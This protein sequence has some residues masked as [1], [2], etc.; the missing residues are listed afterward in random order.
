MK[1]LLSYW[2]ELANVEQCLRTEAETIDEALLLA[3]HEP[4]SLLRRS[5]VKSQDVVVSE[6]DL[7]AELVR[8]VD[9]G[10]AVVVAI[11]GASGVGKS[12]MVRWLRAQLKRHPR[13]DEFV[14]VTIPKTASLRRVVELILEPLPGEAYD[15]LRQDL[16]RTAEALDPD[17]AAALLGTALAE[18]L[19]AYAHRI[20]TDVRAS[21]LGREYGPRVA[22]A[23]HL[24][25]II[26]DP[27]VQDAWFRQVLTRIVRASLSGTADPLARQFH[28]V[29]LDPPAEAAGGIESNAV[30]RSLQF[31]ANAGGANR[32]DAAEVLQEVL[33]PALRTIFRFTEALQ[34][35][36][37][38]E[39]VDDIRRQL[40]RDQKELVLL[41]EDLAA[42]SGI[43]Q[44][45][46]D[47]M[48]A[49][50]DHAGERVRAP[51]RT[52]VAVTDGFLAARQTVLTRAKGQWV[53]QSEG[54]RESTIV[55]RLVDMTGRYLN[56]ARFGV[57]RL[58]AAFAESDA[59]GTGLYEWV[60]KY[61]AFETPPSQLE[62]FGRSAAGHA[63]F[64]FNEYAIRSMAA[65]ALKTGGSWI[66]N[67]R[68]Y[69]NE[70]L[71]RT[72]RLR[73]TFE[74]GQ[75]PPGNF[76]SP[77]VPATVA[78]ELQ[79]K[80]FSPGERERLQTV[81]FHWAGNPG[82]LEGS[83]L[84]S[85]T[86]FDQF[87]LPW[88]FDGEVARGQQ[89][90]LKGVPT[91]KPASLTTRTP[92]SV[93]APEPPPATPPAPAEQSSY[94]AAVEAWRSEV[95]LPQLVA[96]RTRHLLAAALDRRI[97]LSDF[98]VQGLKVE[99][100]LFW[101]PP[102]NTVSN[103]G[104]SQLRVKLAEAGAPIP[105]FVKAGLQALDRW[106]RND[107]R[108]DYSNA[109]DDYA[110]ADV[111]LDAV[112]GQ[113]LPILLDEVEREAGILMGALHRQGLVT[114][115]QGS[116]APDDAPLRQLFAAGIIDPPI[117]ENAL[118]PTYRVALD[119]RKKASASRAGLQSRLRACIGSFQGTGSKVFALDSE[120][121]KRAWRKPMPTR[122]IL[123]LKMR[124]D[125]GGEATDV[126][127][128]LSPEAID[129]VTVRLSGAF[130]STRAKIASAF[131][132]DQA[133]VQWREQ[134]MG[135]IEQSVHLSLWPSSLNPSD[136][137]K[138]VELLSSELADSVIAKAKR[139]TP[140]SAEASSL[141]RLANFSIAPLPQ[142]I[143]LS[144]HIDVLQSYLQAQ[145]KLIRDQS[146]V[147]DDHALQLRQSLIA[148]LRWEA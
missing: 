105:P 5:D 138:A 128:R 34:Q 104:Q 100:K 85:R 63:L 12:H 49:E 82:R 14:V 29:D 132:D 142:L 136:V 2:P 54:L 88:P 97:D 94:A 81:L 98:A 36:T 20:E 79:N 19:A 119:E 47:I 13:R 42:L 43:Q 69:I 91:T 92:V 87:G 10:S 93:P 86:L 37:V 76:L 99:S 137:R 101:L 9:D 44:P 71:R 65:Y 133:R 144:Q 22:L 134:L 95:R 148:D 143:Q 64:P 140:D 103:P 6:Q 127:A 120:R 15:R 89:G 48:I 75:F 16:G 4:V 58:R 32:K 46:L 145:A 113:L 124:D 141:D 111:L 125:P 117:G 72:L 27:A 84:V 131:G 139:M 135:C 90:G 116:A 110:V 121:V 23:R 53:V 33:D 7:L 50:A 70:V 3:V 107:K 73:D 18:E 109:E 52:A 40:M 122:W 108:W 62:A 25:T 66:F 26:R 67:P 61:D 80:G 56:A 39:V 114:G 30:N 146:N 102:E 126:L 77:Q 8:P 24:H 31:L 35:R 45:L 11:T 74:Q 41:I 112:E 55:Q 106:E 130:E 1:E 118:Q 123:T 17:M 59:A 115:I 83:A 38:Q 28:S 21:R 60:P 57:V 68:S 129:S 51:I 147:D 78:L 96:A